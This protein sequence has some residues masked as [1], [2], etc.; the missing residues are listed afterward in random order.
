[1]DAEQR[2]KAILSVLQ[3]ADK[4]ISATALA[5]RFA[6]SRQIIVGDV[7]LLRAAGSDITATPRGYLLTRRQPPDTICRRI[8]CRHSETEMQA[9]LYTMV[10]EGC[11]VKDVIVEHP[12]YGQLTGP[13]ELS[14]RHDVDEFLCRGK[15]AKPLSLLTRG[16]HLH[17]LLC[18]DEAACRRVTKRL[19]E[20]GVLYREEENN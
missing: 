2:R 10:D 1:M 11:T 15:N 13:L 4:A 6:V 3:N 8:A 16:I 5:G 12:L 18:P 17:T 20:P 14:S 7:A 19:A 9:E